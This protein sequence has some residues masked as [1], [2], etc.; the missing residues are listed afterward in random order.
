MPQPDPNPLQKDSSLESASPLENVQC[1]QRD[2]DDPFPEIEQLILDFGLSASEAEDRWI[3]ENLDRLWDIIGRIKN[4]S[5]HP[6]VML[7]RQ[8]RTW[9]GDL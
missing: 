2:P 6:A 9:E 8:S 3:E 5:S 7:L 1:P 4:Q